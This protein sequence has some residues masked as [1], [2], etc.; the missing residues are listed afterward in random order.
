MKKNLFLLF[1]IYFFVVQ[2][3]IAGWLRNIANFY[4][5]GIIN[6]VAILLISIV[7]SAMEKKADGE[8]SSAEKII[9]EPKITFHE[10]HHASV[11]K[12]KNEKG[13]GI[14]VITLLVVI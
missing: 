13:I 1:S 8:D 4:I 3:V 5:L 14:F 6:L 10:Q 2:A 9:R 7:H 12:R 11:P